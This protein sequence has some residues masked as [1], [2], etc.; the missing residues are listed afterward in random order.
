MFSTDPEF[1]TMTS[2]I[3]QITFTIIPMAALSNFL[4]WTNRA[5]FMVPA[6][7]FFGSMKQI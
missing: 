6:E 7:I 1:I 2:S 4:A 5:R 3:K